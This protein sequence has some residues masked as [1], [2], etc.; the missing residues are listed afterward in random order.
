[1]KVTLCQYNVSNDWDKNYNHLA[2]E[3]KKHKRTDLLIAPEMCLT[4]FSF[5]KIVESA[6]YNIAHVENI[7]GLCEL[8]HTAFYGSFLIKKKEKY[9]NRAYFIN[10]EGEIEKHYDKLHLIKGFNEHKYLYPGKKNKVIYYKNLKIGLLVC[11]D[12][13]FAE[14]FRAMA[15]EECDLYLLCAQWPK[16]RINDML[17]LARARALENQAFV[18]LCN[19]TGKAGKFEM[20]GSSVIID[21]YGKIQTNLDSKITTITTEIDFYLVQKFRDDFPVLYDYSRS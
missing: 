2:K 8:Y 16:T 13:R 21:C 3:F 6:N 10:S 17:L 11:Y 7:K 14:Q 19:A 15:K 5:S 12:L 4:G 18:A 1:M 9:Y 20:G